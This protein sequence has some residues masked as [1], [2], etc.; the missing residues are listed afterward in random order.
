MYVNISNLLRLS[1]SCSV[2]LFFGFVDPEAVTWM[3]TSKWDSWWPAKP[4][5]V[6]PKCTPRVS[7]RVLASYYSQHHG[8]EVWACGLIESFRSHS[9]SSDLT[10]L[11]RCGWKL[12][13]MVS[14]PR[15]L[16]SGGDDLTRPLL[17]SHPA[18]M[19]HSH[20]QYVSCASMNVWTAFAHHIVSGAWR[21]HC[22]LSQSNSIH[23]GFLRSMMGW[24]WWWGGVTEG[25]FTLL[26]QIRR[27][28][29]FESG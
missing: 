6:P 13:G 10:V 27:Q 11:W 26:A 5:L 29:R 9:P 21:V 4:S 1:S 19:S 24:W 28:T 7:W 22:S 15:L 8:L 23:L 20:T 12:N 25:S 16:C 3:Y 17:K 2:T 18:L 14:K